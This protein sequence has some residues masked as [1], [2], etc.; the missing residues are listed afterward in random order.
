MK[1]PFEDYTPLDSAYTGY[2][3]NPEEMPV[4]SYKR[5]VV[6][7]NLQYSYLYFR[8]PVT[9]DGFLCI[10]TLEGPGDAI[11]W[12][13]NIRGGHTG[14]TDTYSQLQ[15]AY[16]N[17]N[18]SLPTG[19]MI[20]VGNVSYNGLAGD[21][22]EIEWVDF[23]IYAP[24]L[25]LLTVIVSDWLDGDG[26]PRS[27]DYPGTYGMSTRSEVPAPAANTF[28]PLHNGPSGLSPAG[29]TP[30][31]FGNDA[32]GLGR[33][34]AATDEPEVVYEVIWS[35]E[36]PPP[37]Y[38]SFLAGFRTH[39]NSAATWRDYTGAEGAV[40]PPSY[41]RVMTS[42]SSSAIGNGENGLNWTVIFHPFDTY[43]DKGVGGDNRYYMT[44]TGY[45]Y[46]PFYAFSQELFGGPS[47]YL[48]TSQATEIYGG[49]AGYLPVERGGPQDRRFAVFAVP[50]SEYS[51]GSGE[52]E[53]AWAAL[54]EGEDIVV[55]PGLAYFNPALTWVRDDA[56]ETWVPMDAYFEAGNDRM[57]VRLIQNWK[58]DV[59][60]NMPGTAS[61][62][63]GSQESGSLQGAHALVVTWDWS[64]GTYE[65]VPPV[66]DEPPLSEIGGAFEVARANFYYP[67]P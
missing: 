45:A 54:P 38:S 43:D 44:A 4:G 42:N 13:L 28:V 26:M 67:Q 10:S 15:L 6:D 33:A 37:N 22:P 23:Q 1:R 29:A 25:G 50:D 18:P 62:F 16:K 47:E 65:L 5:I 12:V 35:G 19:V 36:P 21:P 53:T 51:P 39:M 56:F 57:V 63:E 31:L 32:F 24:A 14:T 17:G 59:S 49:G 48:G 64:P 55:H 9:Q 41:W 58:S 3:G 66:W 7:A 27:H 46:S 8:I 60:P 61:W 20:D 2:Y 30:I 40:A 34:Q 11:G 52:I